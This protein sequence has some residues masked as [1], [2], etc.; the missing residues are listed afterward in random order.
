V[1]R[2]LRNLVD[3]AIDH[4]QGQPVVVSL[5]SD[6]HAVA[7]TVRDHGLGLKPGEEKLVFNRFW[8]A[9]PSRAR[10]TGGTGL[11]LSISYER[12]APARRLARRVGRAGQGRPVPLRC[13][14]RAGGRVSGAPLPLQPVDT[15][16]SPVVPQQPAPTEVPA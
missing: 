14:S 3:N 4:G 11:G 2:V 12:R 5:G 13:P 1:E 16:D 10:Q 7:I 8:R 6:S 9:D 15:L